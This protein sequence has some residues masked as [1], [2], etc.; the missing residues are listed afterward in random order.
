MPYNLDISLRISFFSG[1]FR[2]H[3]FSGKLFEGHYV[4]VFSDN[5]EWSFPL[6][7]GRTSQVDLMKFYLIDLGLYFL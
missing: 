5:A 6:F 7:P 3:P 1:Q 2:L 4:S